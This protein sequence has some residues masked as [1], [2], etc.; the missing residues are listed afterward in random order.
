VLPFEVVVVLA[1]AAAARRSDARPLAGFARRIVV[2]LFQIASVSIGLGYAFHESVFPVGLRDVEV[3][4]LAAA[5]AAC[6]LALAAE[7]FQRS[8][9]RAVIWCGVAVAMAVVSADPDVGRFPWAFAV[10]CVVALAPLWWRP[11]RSGARWLVVLVVRLLLPGLSRGEPEPDRMSTSDRRW[12]LAIAASTAVAIIWRCAWAWRVGAE[13]IGHGATAMA[14]AWDVGT[15]NT[16][17]VGMPTSFSDVHSTPAAH[18]GPLFLDLYA[19]FVRVF[20]LRGG[21]FV[22]SAALNLFWWLAATWAAFRAGGRSAALGAWVASGVILFGLM[23]GAAWEPTT[24]IATWPG[25]FTVLMLCWAVATGAWSAW[26]V[27]VIAFG[28]IVQA[29]LAHTIIMLV[30]LAWAGLAIA[31]AARRGAANVRG[32]RRAMRVGWALLVLTWASPLVDI[33]IH[34]GGNARALWNGLSSGRATIGLAGLWRGPAWMLQVPPVW[35]RLNRL[36]APD[37]LAYLGALSASWIPALVAVVLLWVGRRRSATTGE[38]RLWVLCAL[39]LV[40]S[41]GSL[42]AFPLEQTAFYQLMWLAI[43][44]VFVWMVV[45]YSLAQAVLARLARAGRRGPTRRLALRS[46]SW[47]GC[48][49]GLVALAVHVPSSLEA[50]EGPYV[51]VHEVSARLSAAALGATRA[52]EPVLVLGL[53]RLTEQTTADTLIAKL[54][55][56]DRDVRVEGYIGTY[57]GEGR[58]VPPRWSGETLV[59]VDGSAPVHP[60]GKLIARGVPPQW[61]RQRFDRSAARVKAWAVRHGPIVVDRHLVPSLLGYVDGWEPGTSC[62]EIAQID[63]GAIPISK[64][65]AGAIARLYSDAAIVSPQLPSGLQHLVDRD[66]SQTPT[67]VWSVEAPRSDGDIPSADLLRTGALCPS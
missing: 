1:L 40:A 60:A 28:V 5:A 32:A 11:L 51:A 17:I 67:E 65:P 54:I 27:A 55:T 21:A 23:R 13:P 26:P 52:H 19:P 58:V 63:R 48:L 49:V 57:F 44:S 56:G 64:L 47:A 42:V 10:A 33:L 35:G 9:R 16:P 22:G 59:V 6:A 41:G 39:G 61:S 62:T 20:G 36:F 31:T 15:R 37:F 3:R 66:L 30:P 46:V 43:M 50:I 7:M 4:W 45:S 25:I 24:A 29:Y 8:W 18:P 38:R 14:R 2:D 34:R 12:A 53:D